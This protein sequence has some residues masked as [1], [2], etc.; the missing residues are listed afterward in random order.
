[1]Q[2]GMN[3]FS[4]VEKFVSEAFIKSGNPGDVKHLKR[5]VYW[6]KV[7][8]PELDEAMCIAAI[9]HDVERA[10]HGKVGSEKISSSPKGF[11]DEDRLK[12]H[13]ETGAEIISDFLRGV[14]AP[15]EL[16]E[17]STK[18]ISRHEIGGTDEENFLKDADSISYFENQIG[19][20]INNKLQEVGKEKVQKKFDWMFERI[21][22]PV[23]REIAEPMY[24][25]QLI[26]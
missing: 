23:A 20:F 15:E 8:K 22:S 18:L 7:L 19:H 6:L 16:V 1:M 21:T 5:T 17:K 26:D 14:G 25:K 4:K 3:Y 24:Q 10:F 11:I 9:A 2:V 13:Q 12:R